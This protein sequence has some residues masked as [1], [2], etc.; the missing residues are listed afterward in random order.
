MSLF[1]LIFLWCLCALAGRSNA[2]DQ[3]MTVNVDAGTRQCFCH[4][5]S[6]ISEEITISEVT[7][8]ST[9]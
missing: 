5:V 7:F 2:F 8:L 1:L 3:E 6:M 4:Y 9:H